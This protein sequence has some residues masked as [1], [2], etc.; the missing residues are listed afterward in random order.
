[1]FEIID[2]TGLEILGHCEFDSSFLVLFTKNTRGDVIA[3]GDKRLMCVKQI[4]VEG[5]DGNCTP[6]NYAIVIP[7]NKVKKIEVN[8]RTEV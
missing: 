1:M 6:T 5:T 2:I 3:D 8:L 7:L 4:F